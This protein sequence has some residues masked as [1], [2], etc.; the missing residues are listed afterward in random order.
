MCFH[1]M[2]KAGG[3]DAM[4]MHTRGTH[5]GQRVHDAS[6]A[7]RYA[8]M[9][10]AWPSSAHIET[11]IRSTRLSK[12]ERGPP[13][14]TRARARARSLAH[15]EGVEQVVEHVARLAARVG[16]VG[17]LVAEP[18]DRV[19]PVALEDVAPV[20]HAVVVAQQHVA[21]LHRHVHDVVLAHLVDVVEHLAR[22]ERE[23]AEVDVGHAHLGHRARPPVAEEARLVVHV[24]EPRG[25][26]RVRVP[27]HRRLHLLDG[28][29]PHVVAVGAPDELEVHVELGDDRLVHELAR[30][31]HR[32]LL[33]AARQVAEHVQVEVD[34]RDAHLLLVQLLEHRRVEVAQDALAV[35]DE[36]LAAE[37]GGRLEADERRRLRRL[38]VRR[39]VVQPDVVLAQRLLVH[40]LVHGVCLGEELAQAGAVQ[41]VEARVQVERLPHASEPLLVLHQVELTEPDRAVLLQHRLELV[42]ALDE[43]GHALLVGFRRRDHLDRADRKVLLLVLLLPV[44][45][46][47][48]VRIP[49]C[50]RAVGNRIG[51]RGQLVGWRVEGDRADVGAP[52]GARRR[53]SRRRQVERGRQ[54][55]R[56]HQEVGAPHP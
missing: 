46:V 47:Q 25:A 42:P 40:L 15:E 52:A 31:L 18:A 13:L 37:D 7:P 19:Q 22:D 48:L 44:L 27:V 23:V 20:E 53:P 54:G 51:E 45:E 10:Y 35:G 56:G 12:R 49:H 16:D 50:P 17:L 43:V 34:R 55:Q 29:Q 28:L 39:L 14:A 33:D 2:Y 6:P 5:H 8:R 11:R 36:E 24:A 4:V 38:L 41:R 32:L 30:L 3:G 1:D 21:R 9:A 26:P